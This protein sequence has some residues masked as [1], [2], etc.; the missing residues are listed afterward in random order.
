MQISK[1]VKGLSKLI[2]SPNHE[3]SQIDPSTISFSQLN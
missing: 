1:Y 2:D 3:K